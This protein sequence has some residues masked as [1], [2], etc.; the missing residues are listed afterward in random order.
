MARSIQK[1]LN[2]PD[3]RWRAGEARKV[4]AAWRA[5]GQSGDAFAAAHGLNPRRL[6]WW[7]K[8]L[9][10]ATPETLA[11]LTFIPA[12]VTGT[13]ATTMVRLP[14]DVTVEIT[15]AMALPPVW[16]AELAVALKRQS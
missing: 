1:S 4:V 7:R 9:E 5:S 2:I 8:Q 12:D 3:G 16:L 14:G 6:W 13:K 11:P 10:D 15:D